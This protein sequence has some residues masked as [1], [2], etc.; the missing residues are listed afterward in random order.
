MLTGSIAMNYYAEPRMTRDID[1]VMVMKDEDVERFVDE[2]SHD[3]YIDKAY[4]DKWAQDLGVSDLLR[5]ARN[6]WHV[7]EVSAVVA[8]GIDGQVS[9]RTVPDGYPDARIG[10]RIGGG[11]PVWNIVVRAAAIQTF[12]SIL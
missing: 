3:Y 6:E 4:V 1:I 11:F 5:E 9:R 12:S 8:S 10:Q 2:F 7:R